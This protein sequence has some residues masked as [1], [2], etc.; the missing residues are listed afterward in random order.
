MTV[1]KS[2][3]VFPV[4]SEWRG[5][6][7]HQVSAGY[8]MTADKLRPYNLAR[9]D[10]RAH[11]RGVSYQVPAA[12]R[13]AAFGLEDPDAVVLGYGALALYGLPYLVNSQDI[14]L[15][16]PG[17]ARN[18]LATAFTPGL[19]RRGCRPTEVWTV[20]HGE[21]ELQVASPPAAT[22][23]ALKI[24]RN[25]AKS[26]DVCALPRDVY[27]GIELVDCVRRHLGISVGDI[28]AAGAGSI[29]RPWLTRVLA[30]SSQYADS[31]KE[32][33]MRLLAKQV[34]DEF[35]VKLCEQ[36]LITR[37]DRIVTRLDLGVPELRIGAMYDGTHHIETK[38][39]HKDAQINVEL[40][41]LDW[42]VP[43]F[44]HQNLHELPAVWRS[45]LEQALGSR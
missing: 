12:H 33:Q 1:G 27:L 24:I 23:Q 42:K 28:L 16:K 6:H 17:V 5:T 2:Q 31:P 19:V 4:D 36:V 22:I 43:R 30:L 20:W 18:V 10:A 34:C 26:G 25:N 32:T 39:Y 44:T 15:M 9:S 45:L 41:N 40:I 21:R 8:K 14:L 11:P 13:A 7:F 29:H 3:L 35:G 37:G 38:Q